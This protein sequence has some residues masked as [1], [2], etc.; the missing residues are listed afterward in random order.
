MK[1]SDQDLI[2]PAELRRGLELHKTFLLDKVKLRNSRG[3]VIEGRVTD[4][5]P[6]EMPD[7]GIA[8]DHLMLHTAVYEIEYAFAA[9]PEFLTI[10]QDISDENFIFPSE[11]K[12]M[13]HQ[14][15]TELTYTESLRPG[16]AET[17]RFDWDQ[18][19]LSEDAS[20]EAWEAWFEQQRQATLGITSYSSVYS[21][22][23]VEPSEVRHEVLIPLASLKTFLPLQH[24]DPA[25][26]DVAEQEAVRQL[27]RE[28]L[29]D[30]NPTSINGTAVE[31][32]FSRI[33]FYG[34]DLK[35]FAKQ[36]E[37]RRVSL[38]NG[39]VGIIITYRP[40]SDMV[41]EVSLA[42]DTFNSTLRKI[43]S[44]V[45]PPSAEVTQFEFSRFNTEED[46]AFQWSAK[47]DDL[48]EEIATVKAELPPRPKLKLSPASLI[49]ALAGFLG[50]ALLR[51]HKMRL[52]IAAMIFAIVL[53][54][55][56]QLE[57]EHPWQ[58]PEPIAQAA[59]AGI[60][61][62]LVRQ[63]YRSM[64][65]G[66][67][68]RAYQALSQSIDGD[69]LES[70]YL[71]LRESLAMKE[72]GGAVGRV[73]DVEFGSGDTLAEQTQEVLWPGFQFHSEWTV[74]G[75]VEHWGH[76]HQRKNRFSGAVFDRTP[77]GKLENHRHA[78][79]GS[80]ARTG[81]D[82]FAKVS[83]ARAGRTRR[84]EGGRSSC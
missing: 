8:V 54:P 47:P 9:P 40:P 50:L 12:M 74:S 80:T 71:Q 27:I 16:I 44:V 1:P 84:L 32:E 78:D 18:P 79:P 17:I 61:Q 36:A 30:K 56:G 53:W 55:V 35:D 13:L 6:F 66:T 31:A 49:V 26:L 11:M 20:D 64:D 29:Q 68:E 3:E 2:P 5:Q 15:G 60:V 63:T 19:P 43:Q 14:A 67:Q 51:R 57:L 7:N 75:T 41:R 70:I 37:E 25:F 72:Q 33:D 59:A 39:R 48:P 45:I 34:L 69:L 23:Y 22:I 10:Q 38:A 83:V 28:W 4:V 42:W 73:R 82:A 24:T 65:Y 46:N 76:V 58:A 52:F 21:F 77:R 62:Q 81:H